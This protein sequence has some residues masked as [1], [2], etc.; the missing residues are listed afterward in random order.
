MSDQSDSPSLWGGR[1]SEATDSFVQRFTAS[2]NFDQR[3]AEQ[4]IRGSLAHARMLAAT[5]ILSAEELK[6]IEDGLATVQKRN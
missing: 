3:M 4:D 6:A 2:V 5:D 1:F